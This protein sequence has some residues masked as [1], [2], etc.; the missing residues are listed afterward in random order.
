MFL[1]HI[2][3]NYFISKGDYNMQINLYRGK[4]ID[5]NEWVYGNYLIVSY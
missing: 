4:L 3:Y 1:T 5:R 2:I